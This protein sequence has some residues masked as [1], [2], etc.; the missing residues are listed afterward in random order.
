M[1]LQTGLTSR[2]GLYHL[3][4]SSQLYRHCVWCSEHPWPGSGTP[5][6]RGQ[7]A[8]SNAGLGLGAAAAVTTVSTSIVEH[9]SRSSAEMEASGLLSTSIKE[10]VSVGA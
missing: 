7:V 3:Q 9:F 10:K 1:H 8:L 6:S 5:D 2:Q 4:G